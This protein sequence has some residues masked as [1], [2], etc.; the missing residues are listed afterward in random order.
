MTEFV[1]LEKSNSVG[2]VIMNSAP[3]NAMSPELMEQLSEMLGQL[4]SDSE[5]R[6]VLFRRPWRRFLWPVPT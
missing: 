3:A 2:H 6:A 4:E 5:I 1:S